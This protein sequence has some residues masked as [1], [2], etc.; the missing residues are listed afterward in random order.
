MEAEN[1][2]IRRNVFKYA[3]D[4]LSWLAEVGDSE[5][6]VEPTGIDLVWVRPSTFS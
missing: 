5:N 4:E 2:G 3:I 1:D 6:G